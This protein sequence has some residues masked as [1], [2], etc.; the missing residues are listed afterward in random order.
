[1]N[2]VYSPYTSHIRRDII[3]ITKVRMSGKDYGG[4]SCSKY[5]VAVSSYW[6]DYLDLLPDSSEVEL[7][8]SLS[9]KLLGKRSTQEIPDI[10]LKG[11]TFSS[12][13]FRLIAEKMDYQ[14][15]ELRLKKSGTG[16]IIQ[17]TV[18]ELILEH[19]K[20]EDGATIIIKIDQ[21]GCGPQTECTLEIPAKVA[22]RLGEKLIAVTE[23]GIPPNAKLEDLI[24]FEFKVNKLEITEKK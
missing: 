2:F 24:K 9:K 4:Y 12:I 18:R 7:I 10:I 22:R 17:D 15:D 16:K 19:G 20:V 6:S 23:G 1:M 21:S 5:T 3:M 14:F 11:E 13:H 8:N